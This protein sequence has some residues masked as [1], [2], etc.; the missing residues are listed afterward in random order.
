MSYFIYLCFSDPKANCTSHIKDQSVEQIKEEYI[1]H[2]FDFSFKGLGI[3][4][5]IDVHFEK[6][7]P[8]I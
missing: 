5:C 6:D 4:K 8:T 7:L 1:G 2:F 3:V